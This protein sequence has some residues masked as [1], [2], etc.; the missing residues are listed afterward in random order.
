MHVCKAEPLPVGWEI[1]FHATTT[2]PSPS[3]WTAPSSRTRSGPMV[4]IASISVLP[5]MV[6]IHVSAATVG[7]AAPQHARTVAMTLHNHGVNEQFIDTAWAGAL[8]IQ[9]GG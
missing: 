8:E 5:S 7:F 1:A 4:A 9:E 6:L 3:T 2:G